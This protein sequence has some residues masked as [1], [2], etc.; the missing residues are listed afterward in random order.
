M[1]RVY[2]FDGHPSVTIG[3]CNQ[4]PY[5]KKFGRFLQVSRKKYDI[6]YCDGLD[7]QGSIA[8]LCVSQDQKIFIDINLDNLESTLLHEFLH[9][10]VCEG[11]YRQRPEW[12]RGF[13]EQFVENMS[14]ALCH[15]FALKPK[16]I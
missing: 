16:N 1:K 8:G 11:G 2:E 15:N 6:I 3:T 10:E 12:D 13:E 5:R 7:C 9:A 4:G 14:E